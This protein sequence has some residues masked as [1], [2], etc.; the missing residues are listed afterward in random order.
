MFELVTLRKTCDGAYVA[1]TLAF[2][3]AAVSLFWTCGGTWLLDTVGGSIETLARSRAIGALLLGA[4]ATL[5]KGLAGFLAL[6]LVRPRGVRV[7]ARL[8]TGS[9]SRRASVTAGGRMVVTA[10][11]GDGCRRRGGPLGGSAEP[12][13]GW[14]G[15][16]RAAVIAAAAGGL[17]G[18]SWAGAVS[19]PWLGAL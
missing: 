19:R 18:G 15:G 1:V 14:S 12:R 6:G 9:C 7:R 2:V 17:L 4:A 5:V 13:D 3:S 10:V 16:L 8:L 11:G